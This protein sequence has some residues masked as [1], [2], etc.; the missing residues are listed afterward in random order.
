MPMTSLAGR[1]GCLCSLLKL[2]GLK[3]LYRK[4]CVCECK[5]QIEAIKFNHDVASFTND[6]LNIRKDFNTPVNVPEWTTGE[7][8]PDQSPAA[9]AIKETK[10]NVITIQAKFTIAP[11]AVTQ[12]E[13]KAEGGGVL[14]ALDPQIVHFVNGVST[15][16]F[17]SFKLN[18][19]S[20]GTGGIKREDIAWRWKYRCPGDPV[21]RDMQTT[22]H[23][24]YIILEAPTLPW[25]QQPFP[26]NQNPW[27]DALDFA[28]AWAA[29]QTTA[30]GAAT[31]VT[32]QVNGS[33]GLTYDMAQGASKYTTPAAGLTFE[34]TKFINYLKNGIGPGNNGNVVNCTDCGTIVTTFS[35]VV[36]CDLHASKM[37]SAFGFALTPIRAIGQAGF[38]CPNWGCSF[39]FHE[40]AWTGA[41]GNADPIFDACLKVDGDNDPWSA[42]HVEL[43]PADIVF[44]SLPGAPLPLAVPFNANSYRERLC[45]NSNA[46]IGNCN[47]VGPWAGSNNGRRVVK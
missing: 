8:Q 30:V 6:A 15:P 2:L 12:A 9:Y 43:L 21:W 7:T 41:N 47:S 33:L 46:G 4:H 25:K 29:G 39:S 17:V 45:A 24:I 35:N 20:I 19:H 26:D 11:P 34:L 3:K 42:P 14:G 44:T 10:G 16:E 28:C 37:S 18:H 13:I 5:I 38:G 32:S 23:R 22:N 36:G 31:G 27:T 40:V 1:P